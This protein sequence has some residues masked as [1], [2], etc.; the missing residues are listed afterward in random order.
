MITSFLIPCKHAWTNTPITK[1]PGMQAICRRSR[2][3]I[4]NAVDMIRG[5][6]Q[7]SNYMHIHGLYGDLLRILSITVHKTPTRK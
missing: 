4:V 7:S 6:S 3:T 1:V 2:P 5:T